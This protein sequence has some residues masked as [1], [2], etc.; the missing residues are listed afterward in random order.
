MT[1]AEIVLQ[2]SI[3]LMEQGLL[4]P[5][6]QKI[7]ITDEEGTRETFLPEEIH[8]FAAWKKMGYIVKKGEHAIAKFPIWKPVA[9]KGAKK[10][11]DGDEEKGQKTDHMFMKMSFFFTAD[12]V[13]KMKER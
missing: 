10:E 8:T 3:F 7:T 5:T 1:N 6:A 9:K 12:Q 13:E 2:N 11:E 4:K